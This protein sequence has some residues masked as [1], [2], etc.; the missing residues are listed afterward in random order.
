MK[1]LN[2]EISDIVYGD[3]A[4]GKDNAVKRI[5][6]IYF[7]VKNEIRSRLCEFDRIWNEGNE[8][9]IFAELVF[10]ILTPQSKAKSCWAAVENIFDKN[11]LLEGDTHR[12]NKEL[13]EVRF[14]NKKAEYIVEVGKLFSINNRISIKSKIA[15]LSDAFCA[16]DWLAENVK[17]IGYKEASHFLRNIGLGENL[18]ILD[19]HVLKNLKSLGVVKEIP[20][21]LS[22]WRYFEIEKNMKDFSDKISI[23]LGHLDLVF[24]YKETG[25]IFK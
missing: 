20:N 12:I 2:R 17:G 1:I 14:K 8:Q 24:W 13:N 23:P 25:E 6:K 5:K 18:A 15:E 7:Y 3:S 16:R 11:L 22:K 21:S 9:D 19:R 4:T 10:C